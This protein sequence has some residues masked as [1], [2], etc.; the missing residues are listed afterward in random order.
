MLL[1]GLVALVAELRKLDAAALRRELRALAWVQAEDCPFCGCKSVLTDKRGLSWVAY[2]EDCDAEG[3]PSHTPEQA[4][5]L[6][7]RRAN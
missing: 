3:P 2:C 7:K 4:R 5:E 1:Q 6:W